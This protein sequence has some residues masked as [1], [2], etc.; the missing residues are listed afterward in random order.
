M[1]PSKYKFYLNPH[2]EYKWTKCPN[3][4]RKTKVRKHCLIIAY[5]QQGKSL[6]KIFS[7]NKTCK[8]C[9]KCELIIAQQ[10]EIEDITAQMVA[11]FGLRFN[12]KDYTVV[13]TMDRQDWKKGMKDPTSSTANQSSII[14]FEDIW[15]FEIQPGGWYPADE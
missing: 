8:F 4:D 6:E 15:A 5:G 3:C 11:Q 12:P 2:D 10:S 7:L 1:Q 13:G 9:I 14:F